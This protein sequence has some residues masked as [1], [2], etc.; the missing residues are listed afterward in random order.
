MIN[1]LGTEMLCNYSHGR[2]CELISHGAYALH[3]K[4]SPISHDR[5]RHDLLSNGHASKVVFV[6]KNL[7]KIWRD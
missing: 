5:L 4:G 6:Q 7:T 2:R 3:F 1:Y